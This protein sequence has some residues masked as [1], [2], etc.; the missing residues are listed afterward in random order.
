[1]KEYIFQYCS[2]TK[3]Q[4]TPMPTNP[5]GLLTA[6]G[7]SSWGLNAASLRLRGSLMKYVPPVPSSDSTGARPSSR[8]RFTYM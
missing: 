2:D 3:M 8:P 5:R 7:S 6:K 4:L 1:M